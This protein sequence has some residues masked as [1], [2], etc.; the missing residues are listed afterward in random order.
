MH[1]SYGLGIKY[2]AD[3]RVAK[4]EI[5]QFDKEEKVYI[6]MR[7]G[8][9]LSADIFF[10]KSERKNLPT[11]LIRTPY[12]FELSWN[13]VLYS[14]W[15]KNG[16]L[17]IFQ[18]ERGTHWSEGRYDEFLPE[19]KK[20]GYDTLEWIAKQPWS[21]GHIGT[22]GCSSAAENQLGLATLDHPAHK[23]MIPVAPGVGVGQI[24]P[25]Y[26]QGNFYRG[27]ALQSILLGWYKD[28][29]HQHRPQFSGNLS[30][31]E[32]INLAEKYRLQPQQ[33]EPEKAINLDDSFESLPVSGI[34]KSI[35]SPE[36]PI[37]RY[38]Q[39]TP[40]DPEWE[41]LDLAREGD[42]FGVPALW[43]F[44]W[45]DTTVAP[46]I[47]LYNYVQN[48]AF[49]SK[50]VNNQFML[51]APGMHCTQ[52][53]E[54][55][56]TTV[57]DRDLGDARFDYLKLYT[58]W[59]DYWLKGTNNKITKRKKVQLY[60]MGDNQWRSFDQWPVKNLH[61]RRYYLN[62]DGRANS[63]YGTGKLQ[64]TPVPETGSNAKSDQFVYDPAN[65]VRSR[66]RFGAGGMMAVGGYG[67]FNQAEVESRYDVLVYSSEPLNDDVNITG[68]IEAELYVSSD[69]L[70]TDITL[71][72]VDVAPDG[73]AYQLDDSIQ[74]L[75]YREG[76]DK[77]VFMEKDKVYKVKIGPM[78]TS[79][80]FKAG[81]QIRI[82]ITGSNFPKY[83]RN[84]NT[85]GD[86]VNESQWR[87]ARTRIYHSEKYPSHI[88]LPVLK[89]RGLSVLD[90]YIPN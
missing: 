90:N 53:L 61:Y 84:L 41:N 38:I 48:N 73:T 58:D 35:G 70:D 26:E 24:G 55:E 2:G 4:I 21:N 47:A 34:M 86:N 23:A 28:H 17:V 16:Y 18:Y 54:T 25:F 22:F 20:D 11:I 46:N 37:D 77:A 29:G 60:T 65:P 89:S 8:I 68:P 52:G 50:T 74:R 83:F 19:A 9:N 79:N 51:I 45:Y 15:L 6:P 56:Q 88:T 62:S 69:V 81:H 85:G 43:V 67:P 12:D 66:L 72:L 14:H 75:R 33:P 49:D 42:R 3:P 10:P 78:A 30:Q 82:E 80:V 40:A 13:A 31:Q 27:G 63:R 57:G 71:K 5:E 39:R 87:I 1:K 64:L 36:T 32:R 44:S 76:Y 7:D 59:F